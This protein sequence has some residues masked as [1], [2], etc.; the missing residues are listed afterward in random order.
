MK[1]VIRLTEKD[2]TRLIKRVISEQQSND[3]KSAI[4]CVITNLKITKIPDA[5]KSNIGM[6]S[7]TTDKLQECI[8]A[9]V[10]EKGPQVMTSIMSCMDKFNVEVPK[11]PSGGKLPFPSPDKL[12]FPFPNN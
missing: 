5:C 6:E 8:T 3:I 7:N 12:P 4:N 11:L 1:K 9:I 2:L 10:M